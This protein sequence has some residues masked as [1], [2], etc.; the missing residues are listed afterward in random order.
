MG[1]TALSRGE[2]SSFPWWIVAVALAV[3]TIIVGVVV[4]K[5][6]KKAK[7]AKEQ[8]L[9]DEWDDDDGAAKAVGTTEAKSLPEAK[10]ESADAVTEEAVK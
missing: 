6:K 5:K 1:G 3:I 9:W 2:E 8:A 10:P 4:S 7:L